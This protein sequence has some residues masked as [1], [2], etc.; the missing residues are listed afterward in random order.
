MAMYANAGAP[1]ATLEPLSAMDDAAPDPAVLF[2]D[3][4]ALQLGD[5][6]A[7]LDDAEPIAPVDVTPPPPPDKPR[8]GRKTIS[9]QERADRRRKQ[10]RELVAR[11][12]ARV[13]E[14]VA[15]LKEQLAG[16]QKSIDK[17]KTAFHSRWSQPSSDATSDNES[18]DPLQARYVEAVVEQEHLR[19]E[20]EYLE[21]RIDQHLRLEDAVFLAAA[22]NEYEERHDPAEAN[23]HQLLRHRGFWTFFARDNEPFYYEPYLAERCDELLRA[24]YRKA[25]RLDVAFVNKQLPTVCVDCFGWKVQRILEPTN[26]CML[27]FHLT[28]RVRAQN[29][30]EHMRTLAFE[31]WNILNT[32]SLY[33][34]LYRTAVVVHMLQRVDD[35]TSVLIRNMPDRERSLSLRCFNLMR[36]VS[37][38]DSLGRPR[39]SILVLV[40]SPQDEVDAERQAA[41]GVHYIRNAFTY[42]SFVDV[43]GEG[44]EITYGGTGDCLSEVHATFLLVELACV[45]FR[46]EQMVM[47]QRL[48]TVA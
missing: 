30:T 7:L 47:P 45:W 15:S 32:P 48:V 43:A 24:M 25:S 13:R 19:A 5:L 11:G 3:E 29:S 8:R 10:H 28:K 37:D 39:M 1:Y 31:T 20:N 41:H 22:E 16:Y 17:V 9:P 40:M 6:P 14:R 38:H 35:F 4:L 26:K 36:L 33:T 12:R 23:Q 42:M 34:Q 44:V 27:R 2:A 21:E 46:W 18:H